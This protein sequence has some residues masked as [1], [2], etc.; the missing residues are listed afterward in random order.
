MTKIFLIGCNGRMG[1]AISQLCEKE[2]ELEIIAGFD[3]ITIN[4]F[5]YPV[6]NDFSDIKET[7]DVVIDFSNPKLLPSLMEYCTT[8]AIPAVLCTTGY[9]EEDIAL[10]TKTSNIIPVFRS[11][12]MSLGIN[13]L[14]MLA[15]KAAQV[16]GESFDIEII[17]KHHN[18]K[19]DAPSG[20]AIMIAEALENTLTY[21]TERVYD[22]HN[23]RAKRAYNEIG[24][25]SVRGGTIVGE[26]EVIFAGENETVEL[27]HTAQS[28]E[29][30]AS[31]A[32][33][34]AAFLST[35]KEAGQYSMDDLISS[36]VDI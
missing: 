25:H 30:F 2:S 29:V 4:K 21:Q 27:K 11:G 5:N 17:E 33:K 24:M 19:L 18:Q 1:T 9:S 28:R 10:I 26:H 15:K 14:I 20:T 23:V 36:C 32:L 35:I 12:N 16:L 22:R 8:H 13:V 7:P 31:G 3:A 6:Y 34:A